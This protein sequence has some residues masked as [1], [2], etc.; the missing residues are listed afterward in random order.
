MI[1]TPAFLSSARDEGIDEEERSRIVSYLAM[2]PAAGDLIQGTGGARKARF[3]PAGK[4]K[5]GGY[6]VITFC[7]AEDMPVF[8][9]DVYRKGARSDLTQSEKNELR[10]V[11]ALLPKVWREQ[12]TRGATTKRRP[13]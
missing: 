8:L 10:K 9:L 13:Q 2:N 1:E 4:G 7:A 11:L 6:R 12:P 3:A 5:S